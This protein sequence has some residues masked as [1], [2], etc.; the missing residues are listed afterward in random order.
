LGGAGTTTTGATSTAGMQTAATFTGATPAWDSTVWNFAAGSYPTLTWFDDGGLL[1]CP[2]FVSPSPVKGP[3]AGGTT[4][5]LTGTML[6][7]AATVKFGSS[8]AT[9]VSSTDTTVTVQAPAGT[10]TVAVTGTVIE[11]GLTIPVTLTNAYTYEAA[12][13][14][15]GKKPNPPKTPVIVPGDRSMK[16]TVTRGTG[17]GTPTSFTATATPSGRTCT[18]TSSTSG[19]CTI[20][21]LTAGTLYTIKATATNSHGTSGPSQISQSARP[22]PITTPS[23]QPVPKRLKP[24]QSRFTVDG[25]VSSVTVRPGAGRK[26]LRIRGDGFGMDLDG[27]N[28]SGSLMNLT[29]EGVLRI[30]TDRLVECSGFGFK[31]NSDVKLYVDPEV[32]SAGGRVK[33]TGIYVGTLRTTGK[34]TFIGQRVLP[35]GISPGVHDLQAVGLSKANL[36]RVMTLGVLVVGAPGPVRDLSGT[37]TADGAVI[38]LAWRVPAD[39]GGAAVTGYEVQSRVVPKGDW[40]LIAEPTVRQATISGTSPGCIYQVRVRA[41][42]EV[43]HGPWTERTVSVAAGGRMRVPAGDVTCRV[44]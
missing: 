26:G 31:P 38:D 44:T 3:E 15:S 28:S 43:A 19:T 39:N 24:G 5:T 11:H 1:N 42:N 27:V 20:T 17:G 7:N 29:E 10:G 6:A 13:T 37:S 16:V 32:R 21:G 36:V 25:S 12:P 35:P 23:V 18:I 34:G 2:R 22:G 4:V 40:A 8:P 14:P 33:T 30:G 9:I 41:M